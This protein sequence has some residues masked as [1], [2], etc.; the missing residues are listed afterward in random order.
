MNDLLRRLSDGSL[1]VEEARELND[2]L[3][4]NPEACEVYLNHITLEAQLEREFGVTHQ[5]SS[6]TNAIE[7]RVLTPSRPRWI[8][9]AL[10]A[11]AAIVF[12]YFLWPKA[13]SE[14]PVATVLLSEDCVWQSSSGI[15]EGS[16][17]S[18]GQLQL[19]SGM[20]ILRFD[21]GAEAVLRGETTLELQTAMQARLLSGEV[22]IRAEGDAA[23]FKLLTPA[24]ELTDL[25]TEFAVKVKSTGV[26]E[27]QVLDGQVA[28]G[29][30]IA[31]AGHAVRLQSGK[32]A[33]TM[34]LTA[35]RFADIVKQAAPKERRDLMTHYEGFFYDEGTYQTSDMTKGQ[36]WA[37]PWRLRKGIELRNPNEIDSTT[38]MRIVHGGLS[39]P[40][41]IP[42]GRLGGL[43][44]PAGRSFRIRP[45][46]RGIEMAADGITY[47]SLMT[48]E[49]EHSPRKRPASP[50]E[51]VRLTLRSSADYWGPRLSFGWDKKLQPHIQAGAAGAFVS[52]A[53]IPDEQSLLWVGKIIRRSHGEDEVAFRIYGQEDTLDYAEPPTWH[54]VS[55]GLHLDAVFDLVML[56]STGTSPRIVD[57]LR[58]GPTWRS[59][60]P[61]KPQLTSAR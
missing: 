28:Y 22:V 52:P 5:A 9:T 27:L 34:P 3:R 13:G 58:I 54:V 59:V 50:Q 14:T 1:T 44:M 21:G 16:R 12:A 43:E 11:A 40:W 19:A 38:D 4:G 6:M 39:V 53:R 10:A 42:G 2:H 26:T 8:K 41:P 45:M 29:S 20:A 15:A 33:E 18:A 35:P 30:D 48:L 17:L 24:S 23:G 56:S 57:E 47:F 31:N 7:S 61:I 60:V 32:H 51:G 46:K 25:G 55:R 36:G 49:P 37:G